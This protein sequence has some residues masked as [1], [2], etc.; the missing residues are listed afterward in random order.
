MF[1][2]NI[3]SPK[4]IYDWSD[5]VIKLFIV[6]HMYYFIIIVIVNFDFNFLAVYLSHRQ[7]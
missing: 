4:Y 1:D 3:I 2:L 6:Y 7:Q 5:L